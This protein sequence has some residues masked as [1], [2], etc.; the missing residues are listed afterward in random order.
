MLS[1]KFESV[2]SIRFGF[3]SLA[4]GVLWL[5]A[6]M[7]WVPSTKL[8]QQGLVVFLWLPTLVMCWLARDRLL[9]FFVRPSIGVLALLALIV[10]AALSLSWTGAEDV[11][12]EAKRIGYISLFLIASILLGIRYRYESLERAAW[13]L[14]AAF[15]G[16]A[17]ASLVSFYG[18]DGHTST[19]RLEGIG[20]L[21]HPIIGAYVFGVVFSALAACPPLGALRR[22]AWG[23]G[24]VILLVAI[25]LT[26][27]RGAGVAVIGLVCLLPLWKPSSRIAWI[28][29][30]SV[31]IAGAFT[32]LAFES[33]VTA[34]GVS[35]R[36]EIML[37]S[38]RMVM[39]D[40]IFGLG[41]GAPY[42]VFV[43]GFEGAFDHSHSLLLHIGIELGLIG[44]VLWIAIW[45]SMLKTAWS[46]RGTPIG[47]ILFAVLSF[48]IIAGVFDVGQVWTTPR[49]E[50]FV[51]WLPVS[52]WL[53]VLG[54]NM[55]GRVVTA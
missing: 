42:A 2:S 28:L 44:L 1:S 53:M 52:L 32:Y 51:V 55:A 3:I 49:A 13:W 5:L 8:Y 40:P 18:F 38:L 23:L 30:A 16:A 47:S 19:E 9:S 36:P 45:G 27:S 39:D 21:S 50:W 25:G 12:R 20:R 35:Y 31:L 41:I 11:G 7:A 15:V 43:E 24:L 26:Q 6:G 29:A 33:Y 4:I 34:R 22:V 37:S 54:R 46:M 14:G 10:W 17:L 48:S